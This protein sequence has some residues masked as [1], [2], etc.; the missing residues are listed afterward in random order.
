M[1]AYILRRL[2]LIVPTILGIMIVSFT[3][4]QFAP[5][6]PV[7]KI[8]AQLTGTDVAA[9]ARIGGT[10]GGDFGVSSQAQTNTGTGDTATASKYRGAQVAPIKASWRELARKTPECRD[11]ELGWHSIRQSR[12]G[13]AR[14]FVF[15]RCPSQT[16]TMSHRE[17]ARIRGSCPTG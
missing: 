4:I 2:L 12:R 10:G 3:V 15:R 1:T 13:H 9:T 8:I 6:G 7:E 17:S 14:R 5:G 16:E 11:R